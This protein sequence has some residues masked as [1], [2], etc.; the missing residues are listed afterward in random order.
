MNTAHSAENAG[1]KGVPSTAGTEFSLTDEVLLKKASVWEESPTQKEETWKQVF[2]AKEEAAH[3]QEAAIRKHLRSRAVP[4][5]ILILAWSIN[6]SSTATS[7]TG[8][9]TLRDDDA[10]S[11]LNS[12]ADVEDEDC[13]PEATIQVLEALFDGALNDAANFYDS[14]DNEDDDDDEN[15]NDDVSSATTETTIFMIA[16]DNDNDSNS[17]DDSG[18]VDGKDTL[19]DATYQVVKALFESLDDT[20]DIGA[21]TVS[22]RSTARSAASLET[23]V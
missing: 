13:L 1:P 9:T 22:T 12:E 23:T 16:S 8:G 14:D 21:R 17:S 2:A 11:D 20:C 6:T 10:V 19:P 3:K 7:A 4:R 18:L 15:S 5:S